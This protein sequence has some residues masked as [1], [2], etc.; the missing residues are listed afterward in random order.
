MLEVVPHHNRYDPNLLI[1]NWND[2]A[3]LNHLNN[4]AQGSIY[5]ENRVRRVAEPNANDQNF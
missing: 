2:V 5:N 3:P 1:F 4:A